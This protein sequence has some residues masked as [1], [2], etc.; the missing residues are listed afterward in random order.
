MA[1]LVVLHTKS[2]SL[3][4][5]L[6]RNNRIRTAYLEYFRDDDNFKRQYVKKKYQTKKSNKTPRGGT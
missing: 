4:I 3:F 5:S 1:H 2:K 6:N